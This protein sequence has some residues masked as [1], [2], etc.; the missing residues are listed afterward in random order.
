MNAAFPYLDLAIGMCF[1]Y[2]LMAL[3]C[4]TIN[5]S[6]AGIL[7]SRGKT[8]AQG[9]TELLRDPA[10]KRLVYEHPLVQGVQQGTNSRL[11]SYLSSDKFALALTNV[12][13]GQAA[14]D[15][16][17]GLRRGIQALTNPETKKVLSAVLA[18]SSTL[19]EDQQRLAAWYDQGM[20][21]I[22][23]WYK[24]TAQIRVFVL[25]ALVTIL[26]NADTLNMLKVLWYNPTLS[27]LVLENAKARQQQGTLAVTDPSSGSAGKANR[28][29]DQTGSNFNPA[30]SKPAAEQA[31]KLVITAQEEDALRQITGWNGDWYGDWKSAQNASAGTGVSDWLGY[32]AR[33]RLV[34]WL[35]TILAVS[36][37]A[38]FWFDTL[39]KFM[40]VRN[41]GAPPST[42]AERLAAQKAA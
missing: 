34:G 9:I 20:T 25:A 24:R 15:D 41:A 32:L 8:L 39:S 31:G 22:S 12:L 27:A 42:L 35:I 28:A 11:P 30:N 36:L 5:E 2:L 13:T 19:Q 1:V 37:G 18:G 40:N 17:A 6:L 16:P 10:L 7:N 4:T 14:V 29:L 38:P 3:I 33:Q 23:G 21:R 26:L